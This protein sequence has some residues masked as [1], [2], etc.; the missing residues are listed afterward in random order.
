MAMFVY[1]CSYVSRVAVWVWGV[2][3]GCRVWMAM[4]VYCCSYV[5]RVV[6]GDG[7]WGGCGWLCL[8]T[9]VVTSRE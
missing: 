5:S 4:C 3:R 6:G 1:S 2:V 7:G 9:V 8:F